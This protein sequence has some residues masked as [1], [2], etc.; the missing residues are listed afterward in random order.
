MDAI[1]HQPRIYISVTF[2]GEEYR[3]YFVDYCLPTLMAPGNI[4]AIQN[5]SAARLLVATRGDD[6]QA[7]QS[8]PIFA[9]AKEQITVEH[10]PYEAPLNV[11]Y[12]EKMLAMS[13]GHKL[14]TQRMFEDRAHGVIVY[15][16]MILADEAIRRIEQLAA[17][18]YKVVL[19]LAVRFANEGLIEEL[20]ARRL[21]EH[22]KPIAIGAQE[23]ARL[24]IK[25]MH[26]E[27]V[28]L[29][30][31]ADLSDL[32]GCAFFW[33]VT[34]GQ[35]LLFHSAN[36]APLLIDYS[37]LSDHDSSTLDNWTLDGDYI[38]KNF[39]NLDEIYVVRNTTELFVSGFTPESKISY[40]KVPFPPYRS[41]FLRPIRKIVRAREFMLQA[42]VW[43]NVK[44]EL[45]R[46]PIR[47]QGG[48]ASQS[49]WRK[50]E[51]R[52]AKIVSSID[53]ET[54][55]CRLWR[56]R[57]SLIFAREWGMIQ[58][59]WRYR[60]FVWQRVK[61][62]VG[63]VRGRSRV[64]D[65]RDWVSPARGPMR[66]IWSLRVSLRKRPAGAHRSTAMSSRAL[67]ADAETKDSYPR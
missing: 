1:V 28:R 52:A 34:P 19:C 50:A 62:K 5:K 65:G 27:T 46:T 44:R 39:S 23:L 7:L 4:P 59:W 63:L 18:G 47:L 30:F 41:R 56:R 67:D 24:T 66:P 14:L 17:N 53:R 51:R 33:V 64:D 12:D 55:V 45:F 25:H 54:I 20:Q 21:V 36:W 43:D 40:P 32:G 26:S 9:A 61:E 13:K 37:T 48:A 49:A 29:D 42:G 3:R 11:K 38:A 8:E 57:Q 16:D 58:W 22:G 31:K 2:W 60:R 15:P 10:V 6:W 35:D